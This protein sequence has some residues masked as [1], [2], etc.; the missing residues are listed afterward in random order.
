M[1]MLTCLHIIFMIVLMEVNG[2]DI[3]EDGLGNGKDLGISVV[4]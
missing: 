3:K 4:R 1:L 2:G